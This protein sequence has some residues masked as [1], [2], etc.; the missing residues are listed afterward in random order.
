MIKNV[1]IPLD[2]S[3][4]STNALKYGLRI[5]ERLNIEKVYLMHTLIVPVAIGESGYT[6]TEKDLTD[7]KG[8]AD[9]E[10]VKLKKQIPGL[11]KFDH[12]FITASGTVSEALLELVPEKSIDL[13]I[14]G[15]KGASGLEEVIMGTN[16]HAVVQS[17]IA[18]VLIVPE[19]AEYHAIE[20]IALASDYRS[21]DPAILDTFKEVVIKHGSKVHILHTGKDDKLNPEELSEAKKFEQYL[22]NVKHDFH[23][24]KSDNVK[25]GVD[26]YIKDNEIG[27]L[28]LIPRKHKFF[29]LLFEGGESS[30]FIY[31]IEVPVL[32][33]PE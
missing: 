3:D 11:N 17:S 5:L 25:K 16:A 20:N 33:L 27:M 26:T 9:Q 12:E 13:I 30:K 19:E 10:F 18:P 4:C 31:E 24:L 23:Y 15:T 29:K 1:I 21:I 28:T 22:K 6:N 7:H 8:N 14:M 32:A 2:F